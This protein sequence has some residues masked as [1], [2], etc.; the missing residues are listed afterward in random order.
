MA[1]SPAPRADRMAWAPDSRDRP[2]AWAGSRERGCCCC[3]YCSFGPVILRDQ[4]AGWIWVA[5][6]AWIRF[7]AAM[8][9]SISD[10]VL[11]SPR[12]T[13]KAVPACA[14]SKPIAV[15]TWLGRTLP[16][17]QADPALT[18]MPA[19][20][21]AITKVSADLAPALKQRVFGS[22]ATSR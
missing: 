8:K 18:A 3:S 22:R 17:E 13:R 21:N 11:V 19:R 7:K 9:A 10:S 14:G 6:G 12:L 1:A 2:G 15:T 20:S 4:A 16:E 5:V